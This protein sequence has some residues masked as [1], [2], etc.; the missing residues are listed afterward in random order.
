MIEKLE[1]TLWSLERIN[2]KGTMRSYIE[3]IVESLED[4]VIT[5][6]KAQSIPLI[7]RVSRT[8]ESFEVVN[9]RLKV[10]LS[11]R[12]I[13]EELRNKKLSTKMDDLN[14][15][16]RD[17]FTDAVEDMVDK[18]KIDLNDAYIGWASSKKAHRV[19][20]MNGRR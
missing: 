18:M 6:D 13:R 5:I 9:Y 7:E 15:K 17:D 10:K 8:V 14:K 3:S 20:T 16:D 19:D 11:E 12:G 2:I 1:D 4:R